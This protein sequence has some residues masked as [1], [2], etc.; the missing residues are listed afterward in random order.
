MDVL[1][2]LSREHWDTVIVVL[3]A[4][5]VLWPI[6]FVVPRSQD[7]TVHLARAWIVGQNLASGHVTGWSPTWF[8]GF[9]A[10]E[11]YPV[12][13][14]LA[15][16]SLR[17]LTFGALPWPY[18]YALAFWCGYVLAAL[19]LVRASRVLG[20][21]G[22]PGLVAAL[23]FVLDPGETREGGYRF[24]AFF[25]VW[26]A[27]LAV[28]W[29]W[30]AMAKLHAATQ[31]PTVSGRRLLGVALPLSGALLAH[32][33][34]LPLLM[35]MM[36]PFVLL[37][38]RKTWMRTIVAACLAVAIAGTLTAWH[39]LPMMVHRAWTGNFGAL[40]LGLQRMIEEAAS[41]A[42]TTNMTAPVGVSITAGLVWAAARGDRFARF[43]AAAA[44]LTWLLA[45]REAFWL[46]RL[47]RFADAFA[48]LQYQ[49]FVMCAK[50]GFFLVT[51]VV[52]TAAVRASWPRRDALR[53]RPARLAAAL[54]TAA[55]IAWLAHGTVTHAQAKAVGAPLHRGADAEASASFEESW[56]EY[57]AWA[58]QRWDERDG[59]FRIAYQ[60]VSRHGHGFADA[61]VFTGAPAF[62]IGSTPGES[63]VHRVESDRSAVLDRLR[64]RYLV[65]LVPTRA[66]PV[67][68]FGAISV[69]ERAVR[70]DVARIVGPGRVA[71]VQDDV[72]HVVV[73]VDGT[74]GSS[75]LE[76]AIAGYPRWELLHDGE[77]VEWY[78]VPVVGS[79]PFAT[80][81]ER[82]AG[83]FVAGV[84]DRTEPTEPMLIAAD[85]R[86]GRWELRYRRVLPVDLVGWLLFAAGIALVLVLRRPSMQSTPWLDRLAAAV[87]PW[88]VLA[89]LAIAAAFPVRR[90]FERRAAEAHLASAQLD[91]AVEVA[92]IEACALEIDRILGPAA[93]VDPGG[94]R[95]TAT[96]T[97][98]WVGAEP[99]TGYVAI[100][101]SSRERRGHAR[102][103]ISARTDGGDW[104]PIYGEAVRF[105][106]PRQDLAIDL[107]RFEPGT[108]IDLRVDLVDLVDLD[109]ERTRLGFDFDLPA[110]T[111]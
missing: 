94:S 63:F 111:R 5:I 65:T 25:G 9:P 56:S 55:W 91:D 47:D 62:K 51:G 59:F 99:L 68:K 37:R 44:L 66:K 64:V 10:G 24:T 1:R 17:A 93:C 41:G 104:I 38:P 30:L 4:A 42:W 49:R 69:I 110:S 95:A 23:L 54:V 78:E 52:V 67:A 109:A 97:D 21:G 81:A 32:P 90:W 53:R 8:F 36:V 15:V 34:T 48:A 79:G 22:A 85:A 88:L 75:R 12:L 26:L 28:S 74:D 14:D 105:S 43:A 46:P 103:E 58:K 102:L 20:W 84:A 98:R 31:E 83:R 35:A 27:P 108:R 87:P 73:D 77:P 72:D 18:C 106:R 61:P 11:L 39:L 3:V 40:H 6:P 2:R 96:F 92:G 13:G 107:S 29:T 82:R 80:Q 70:D 57:L 19:A 50:P 71:I 76:L 16:S 7:H 89:G 101:D 100:D 45:S 33:M 60:T 86:D